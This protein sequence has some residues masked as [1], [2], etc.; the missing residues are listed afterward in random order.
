[1]VRSFLAHAGEQHDTV[2]AA[3]AHA[4][5]NS[6]LVLWLILLLIP[7]VI[8]FFMHNIFKTKPLNTLLGISIFLMGYSVYTY[9]DPGMH[10]FIA[11]ALGFGI[12]FVTSLLRFT[13][14]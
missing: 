7:I 9:Q 14:E 12:V 11:L 6:N 13:S 8:T 3:A 4:T 1:M 10:T 2:E 5:Q